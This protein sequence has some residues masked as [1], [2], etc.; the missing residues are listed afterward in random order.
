[1]VDVREVL[2]ALSRRRWWVIAAV[3][4]GGLGGLV[5]AR[6]VAPVYDASAVIRITDMRRE[7]AGELVDP[8]LRPEGTAVD[9]LQSHIE[10]LR[11]RTLATRVIESPD[12]GVLRVRTR[13]IPFGS[14]EKLAVAPEAT[15]DSLR[16]ESSASGVT[17]TMGDSTVTAEHGDSLV[18]GG[19]SFAVPATW[20]GSGTLMLLPVTDAVEEL[21]GGVIP[22]RRENTN[23]V[24]VSFRASD[25][26]LAQRGVNLLVTTFADVSTEAAR[27]RSRARRVFLEKQL[28]ANEANLTRARNALAAQRSRG[29]GSVTGSQYQSD[30][31]QLDS[32]AGERRAAAEELGATE[33]LLAQLDAAAREPAGSQVRTALSNYQASS[34]PIVGR[35]VEELLRLELTRDSLTAGPRGLAAANPAVVRTDTLIAR[36]RGRLRDAASRHVATL[37]ERARQ[38]RASEDRQGASLAMLPRLEAEEVRLAGEQDGYS[39]LG[40][41]LNEE[42]QRALISEAAESGEIQ[43]VDLATLPG[44]SDT[45]PPMQWLLF[46]LSLGL[47]GGGTAAIAAEQYNSSIRRREEVEDLLG[48]PALGII[49][50]AVPSRFSRLPF[51]RNPRVTEWLCAEAFGALRTNLLFAHQEQ[52][53]RTFTVTSP[54]QGEGKSTVLANLGTAFARQGFRVVLI[55]CDLRRPSLH[56]ALHMA[57]QPGLSEMLTGQ[58]VLEDVIHSTAI[59]N[60]ALVPA[61]ASPDY[62]AELLG[63]EPMSRLLQAV[64][65]EFDVVLVD[66]PPALLTTDA[67]VLA[68]LTEGTILVL[69]AGRTKRDEALNAL[70]QLE[71]VG[72][73]VLGFVL[74]DPDQ[75]AI[76]S[77]RDYYYRAARTYGRIAEGTS[78]TSGTS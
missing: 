4:A 17:V 51:V 35:L 67:S 3:V 37:T 41:Q 23:V 45:V 40:R 43:V 64:A 36:V 21:R 11:S 30:R 46:G 20:Q 77:D 32:L 44:A 54:L 34:S 10:L 76:G 22:E 62:P 42:Y 69:C 14:L 19:V 50:N 29:G 6:W 26:V 75:R 8:G 39:R 56:R 24:D 52:A 71:R 55:D 25:P 70:Q 68:A 66:T 15:L 60:L 53:S 38:L 61:G 9:P 63:G 49:P 65:D 2:G 31:A 57:R 78:G 16:I 47:L 59:P 5:M 58:S 7:L 74:N 72:A 48:G 1:M 28:L 73:N 33:S 13:E 12:G 18:L 27:E